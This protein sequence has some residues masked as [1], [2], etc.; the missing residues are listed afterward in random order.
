[1]NTLSKEIADLCANVICLHDRLNVAEKHIG[2]AETFR[3]IKTLAISSVIDA[4]TQQITLLSL[5]GYEFKDMRDEVA[6]A[7][8][9]AAQAVLEAKQEPVKSVTEDASAG[10]CN[11]IDF[12]KAHAK[13]L[14]YG[15]VVWWDYAPWLIKSMEYNA[16]LCN[17]KLDLVNLIGERDCS[18]LTLQELDTIL[19]WK[20]H[21]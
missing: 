5:L 14:D 2:K 4:I 15:E 19:R 10:V 7:Q 9:D 11:P 18:I 6:K 1:M 13:E 20:G 16:E 17:V 21:E 8:Q 12:S 3:A